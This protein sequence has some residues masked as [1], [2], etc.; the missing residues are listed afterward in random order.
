MLVAKESLQMSPS[1]CAQGF[2]SAVDGL[3]FHVLVRKAE[4]REHM[5]RRG[6]GGVGSDR[7]WQGALKEVRGGF[8]FRAA[9]GS[10]ALLT[11]C[12]QTLPAVY[13]YLVCST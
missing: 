5:E 2:L 1:K 8:S 10:V 11:P 3:K 7:P 13:N 6:E 12:S 4:M 9:G